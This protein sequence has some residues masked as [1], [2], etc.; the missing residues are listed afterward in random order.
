M[1]APPFI[2]VRLPGVCAKPDQEYPPQ[3][4]IRRWYRANDRGSYAGVA[5]RITLTKALL[6]VLISVGQVGTDDG[7]S[8]TIDGKV[9]LYVMT[10][11]DDRSVSFIAQAASADAPLAGMATVSA[12]P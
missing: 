4:G 6:A 12:C 10:P 5:L 1:P 8:Y 2:Q 7:T 11:N 3:L 9:I